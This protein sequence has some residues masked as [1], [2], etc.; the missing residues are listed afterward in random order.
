[1]KDKKKGQK[2]DWRTWANQVIV[3]RDDTEARAVRAVRGVL[4][5]EKRHEVCHPRGT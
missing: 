1:M 2:F 5:E 4:A 3:G